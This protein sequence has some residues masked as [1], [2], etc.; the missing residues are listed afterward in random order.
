MHRSFLSIQKVDFFIHP[1]GE[2]QKIL[3][4]EFI[5]FSIGPNNKGEW[6]RRGCGWGRVEYIDTNLVVG[7]RSPPTKEDDYQNEEEDF[8]YSW[9]QCIS[10]YIRKWKI[11]SSGVARNSGKEGE[12]RAW[13]FSFMEGEN[14]KKNYLNKIT[15]TFIFIIIII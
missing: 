13:S 8:K 5:P 15:W 12:F 14:K 11:N 10:L 2:R 7:C 1:R 3:P 6:K 4:K 9:K